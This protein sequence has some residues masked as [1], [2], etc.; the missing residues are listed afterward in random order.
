MTACPNEMTRLGHKHFKAFL[1][2]G[3]LLCNIPFLYCMMNITK[4]ESRL[5]AGNHNEVLSL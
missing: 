4:E 1:H 3:S 5:V 2:G